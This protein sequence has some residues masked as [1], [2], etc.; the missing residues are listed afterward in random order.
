MGEVG[1]R[2]INHLLAFSRNPPLALSTYKSL[3]VLLN[4][5]LAVDFSFPPVCSEWR[6]L[7]ERFGLDTNHALQ[8]LHPVVHR[9]TPQ[10]WFQPFELS[11]LSFAEIQTMDIFLPDHAAETDLWKAAV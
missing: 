9:C 11:V 6:V 3:D 4:D 5:A 8:K 10:G 2:W 1:S 7:A